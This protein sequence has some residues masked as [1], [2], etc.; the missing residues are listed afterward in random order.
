[1]YYLCR[2][3]CNFQFNR[4]CLFLILL[5]ILYRYFDEPIVEVLFLEVIDVCLIPLK[6]KVNQENQLSGVFVIFWGERSVQKHYRL[7][8]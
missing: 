5:R 8:R 6:S 3:L 7:E 1:M 2:K 4:F